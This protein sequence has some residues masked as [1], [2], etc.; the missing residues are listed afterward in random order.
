M[1]TAQERIPRRDKLSMAFRKPPRQ[2]IGGTGP[3]HLRRMHAPFREGTV[4]VVQ[5]IVVGNLPP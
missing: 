5:G 4:N 1:S 3:C 2:T